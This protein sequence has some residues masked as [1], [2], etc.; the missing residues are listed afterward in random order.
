MAK[1]DCTC[2]GHGCV[3][4]LAAHPEGKTCE[5]CVF[6]KRCKAM[7]GV[8]GG[9]TYC[10]WIPSRFVQRKQEAAHA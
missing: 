8:A 2:H 7:F 4:C 6:V 10:S 5:D 1:T 3:E 9:E